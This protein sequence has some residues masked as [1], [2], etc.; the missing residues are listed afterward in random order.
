MRKQLTL[1]FDSDYHCVI[2][3]S[4]IVSKASGEDGSEINYAITVSSSSI[5]LTYLPR[6]GGFVTTSVAVDG[7]DL[8]HAYWHHIAVTVFEDEAA[9]YVNGSVVAALRL[10][11]SIRDDA[12]RN[13]KLG[14]IASRE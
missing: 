7:L 12:S 11:G 9:I 5:R 8:N 6:T 13:I 3:Y 4:A 1:C 14:Q 2:C 10:V